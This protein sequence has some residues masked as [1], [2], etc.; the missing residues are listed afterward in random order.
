[1]AKP[2]I[3]PL[4]F[5]F[6]ETEAGTVFLLTNP[7]EPTNLRADT[8]VTV[9]TYSPEHLALAKVRGLIT[10]VGYTTATFAAVETT[11]DPRWPGD[12]NVLRPK[13][14]VFLALRES[15]DPDSSRML[16]QEQA[17]MME[18]Y[19]RLYSDRTKSGSRR[20]PSPK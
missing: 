11:T 16:T 2:Y 19:A 18:A 3:M 6:R 1:M 10:A 12:A 20:R 13:T 8:P 7:G 17:N 4:G 14:P 5:I 15:F 9:W